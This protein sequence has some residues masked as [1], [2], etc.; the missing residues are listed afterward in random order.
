[1]GVIET[2]RG[3]AFLVLCLAPMLAVGLTI[4]RESMNF[5]F[6]FWHMVIF[7]LLTVA[8]LLVIAL[9]WYL[10]TFQFQ[11]WPYV[12]SF[13]I[14][15][16]ALLY[17]TVVLIATCASVWTYFWIAD[18]IQKELAAA[19]A[20]PIVANVFA[21]RFVEIFSS[22]PVFIGFI[23]TM[24]VTCFGGLVVAAF[25]GTTCMSIVVLHRRKSQY[26]AMPAHGDEE[27]GVLDSPTAARRAS[28]RSNA[29][30]A[31]DDDDAN[32]ELRAA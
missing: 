14:S 6:Y 29:A 5:T 27:L 22:G 4:Y 2:N 20:T 16:P 31:F 9:R 1:M 18:G 13:L 28:R 15:L 10:P 19:T 26:H 3:L 25:V 17:S 32:D 8:A 12:V 21:A 30:S 24:M 11:K 23:C 7:G